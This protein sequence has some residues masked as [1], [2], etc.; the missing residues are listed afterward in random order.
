MAESIPLISCIMPTC[1]RREFVPRAIAHFQRQDY[2]NKELVV[3]DDGID[4]IADLLPADERI[5]LIRLPRRMSVGAK[6]NTACENS[7]GQF[8][9]HWDDDDWHASHRLSYQI[10]C[11]R[12]SSAA[13]CGLK[14]LLFLDVRT[15][16]AWQYNYPAG[17]RP[18][19]SGNSLVYR[20][21]FWSAHRFPD[22]NVGEDSRFVWAVDPAQLIVLTDPTFHVGIIHGKNVSPKQL[23][24]PWWKA[25]PVDEIRRLLGQDWGAVVTD[26]EDGES[27]AHFKEAHGTALVESGRSTAAEKRA[28]VPA[29]RNVFACLVHE[30]PDCILDLIR[31]LKHLDPASAILVYNG[32]AN[33]RLLDSLPLAQ[34]GAIAHPSP[35]PMVW[36]KLHGFALD[37]MRFG[38][39]EFD[40]QTLTIVDSDQLALRPGY[41]ARLAQWLA[42]RPNVGMLG[43][44]PARQLPST[45]VA[46]V[47]VAYAEIDLWRPLLKRF[48]DG[49]DKFAH[50][51]FWPSTV[52]TATAAD[53]LVQFFDAD[54][55]FQDILARSK[56]WA[57]EEVIL[58]TLTALLGH[59]L[60]S[61]PC[62]YDFVKYR[63]PYTSQQIQQAFG[64]SDVFWAHPIPRRLDDP[65]RKQIRQH[66][67]LYDKPNPAP[68]HWMPELKSAPAVDVIALEPPLLLTRPILKIMRTIEGWLDEDEG[69]LLIAAAARALTE[70]ADALAIVEVGSY[71]GRAT[72]ILALVTRTIRAAAKVYAIDPHDGRVGTADKIFHVAPSLKRL[73]RNL[74]S[75][76]TDANVEVIQSSARDV[77]WNAPIAFLLIDGLHDYASVSSDFRYFEAF[78]VTGGYVAFHDYAAYFPGVMAFVGELT[79]S[80][81]YCC[82]QRVGSFAL[83]KKM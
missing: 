73:K 46:P 10:G 29:I 40:F 25:H 7:L 39:K 71:C 9:A 19:L 67:A 36:G 50:W 83:L 57:T 66:H 1:D 5:R 22:I 47:M 28:V 33:P 45:Q 74:A 53:G 3:V 79:A 12:D 23:G 60:G 24:G 56:I 18:W 62:S 32:S 2:P 35:L 21:E 41:S 64:R 20:R 59:E 54:E 63:F 34:Y 76:G 38:R 14:D 69:D 30:S 80:Q 70:N 51:S 16:K 78:L 42:D 8:I 37:C 58:P 4:P 82:V 13:I 68:G 49:E 17:L 48:K 61:N 6:R 44:S 52:Y 43:N 77:P 15:G 65:L 26:A 27:D 81:G 55:Q 72:T 11:L 75:A 31:N